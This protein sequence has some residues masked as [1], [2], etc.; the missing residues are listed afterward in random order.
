MEMQMQMHAPSSG[1]VTFLFTDLQACTGC[2]GEARARYEAAVRRAVEDEGGVAYKQIGAAFQAAFP[3]A[4]QA[5]AAAVAL[6]RALL[7]THDQPDDLL[8]CARI[9]L[10]AGVTEVRDGDYFGP[11]LNRVARLLEACHGGQVLLS[12]AAQELAREGL[13][14]DVALRD[15][16]EHRLRDL[17]RPERV[18]QL[19]VRGLPGDF[20]PIRTLET[21]PNNLPLQPTPLI[22]REREVREC[23]DLLRRADVWLLTLTGP[24]GTGKTR[25]ALQVAAELAEEF[26]GGVFFVPLDTVTDPALVASAIAR[27]LGLREAQGHTMLSG[28]KDY[29]RDRQLLLVLDNFEQVVEAGPVVAELLEAA[30]ELKVLVTSRTPLH[31]TVEHEYHV[32]PLSVPTHA[33]TPGRPEDLLRYE[34]VALFVARAQAA[35]PSFRLTPDNAPTVAEV[36]RRLEGLPLAIELAAARIR[37]LSPQAMLARLHS[38]LSLLT[39]GARDLP[40]RQQA[41]RAT[42]DWSYNLLTG[43]ERALFAMLSVFAGG[44]TLESA[45]AVAAGV[46][47]RGYGVDMSGENAGQEQRQWQWPSPSGVLDGLASLVDK[48]LLRQ[49]D[50]GEGTGGPEPRFSMMEMIREYAAEL[51]AA[52]S[53]SEQVMRRYAEYFM[54]FTE[55]AERQIFSG[56]QAGWLDRLEVEHD[57]LRE[58]L[59]HALERGDA[60]LGL[61]VAGALWRFWYIR[62]YYTEGRHWLLALLSLPEAAERTAARAKAL[63]GAGNL[64]YMLGQTVQ[65]QELQEE[66]L[67]IARQLGDRASMAA[68]YNNLGHLALRRG[69][70]DAAQE[71]LEE[72]LR[73]SVATG[74]LTMQALNLNNMGVLAYERGRYPEARQLQ[75]RSLAIFE[76]LGD[77]W[78]AAM[79]LND[80]G[81]V[82][83]EQGDYEEARALYERGL[84]LLEK[85]GDRAGR[86]A[87]LV[88]LGQIAH[89]R[90]DYATAKRVY[91]QSLEAFRDLGDRRGTADALHNLGKVAFRQGNFDAARTLFE[92]SLTLRNELNDKRAVAESRNNLGL[93]ALAREDYM[94]A[95]DQL[96]RS[97]DLWREV[98]NS[99]A[100]PTGLNNLGLV[101]LVQGEYE[102]AYAL[103]EE[104]LSLFSTTG[105]KLGLAFAH[106]NMGLALAGQGRFDEAC[107]RYAAGLRLFHELGDRLHMAICMARLAALEAAGG[108]PDRA[109]VL[110]GAAQARLDELGVPLPPFETPFYRPAINGARARLG[111]QEFSRAW[112]EGQHMDAERAFLYALSEVGG[113]APHA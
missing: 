28:L 23:S 69:D 78:G 87:V 17:T 51:L 40:A 10:H 70:Y 112:A 48:N 90:S 34:A 13:P 25:V 3:T 96:R 91:E 92:E 41:L 74:S 56:D 35:D 31:L 7:T 32:P 30:P 19:V 27:T 82:V 63:R 89:N 76:Q 109:A 94:Y 106:M 5:V 43:E 45:E 4:P 52:S 21:S 100:I 15:L 12:G 9:A 47:D 61:R 46:G 24:A 105:E 50:V 44:C 38:Q 72:G 103:L 93:V 37:V 80:L 65:A 108:R 68:L 8:G 81:N 55:D 85:L 107:E 54:W 20:P 14:A 71:L 88:H 1:T 98:G 58:V 79:S 6:Q 22:G 97:L 99:A 83:F 101:A 75:E 29:L 64:A 104:S 95:D 113:V 53:W 16:G 18:F 84:A 111:E 73:L 59:R 66:S 11:A 26:S 60:H 67:S 39:G 57:N 110:A 49:R 62:G 86:A 2:A 42:L 77:D 33:G 102:A 36:C